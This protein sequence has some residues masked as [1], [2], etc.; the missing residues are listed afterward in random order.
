M[1]NECGGISES[2]CRLAALAGSSLQLEVEG[3]SVFLQSECI[4]MEREQYIIISAPRPFESFQHKLY[5]GSYLFVKYVHSGIVYSFQTRVMESIARPVRLL[6]LEY[7]KRVRPQ[8]LRNHKRVSCYMPALIGC[9]DDEAIGAVMDINKKG[10]RCRVAHDGS[11]QLTGLNIRDAVQVNVSFPGDDDALALCG[12]ITN[13]RKTG[14]ETDFGMHFS[15]VSLDDE[16]VL[17][18]YILSVC[19]YH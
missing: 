9:D 19:D 4:G 2:S 14:V 8:D 1:H 15:G 11:A 3:C 10:C 6:F 13:M 16:K 5:P 7:P 18:K 17:A 12:T